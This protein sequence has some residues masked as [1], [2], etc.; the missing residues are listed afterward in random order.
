MPTDHYLLSD[1][2]Y[3]SSALTDST[4][5]TEEA[6]DTDAY[7]N[8]LIFSAAGTGGDWWADDAT[9]TKTPTN[10]LIFTGRRYDP[11]AGI[12]FYRARYYIPD[13]GRF[14]C[15]DP[16][17]YVDGLSLYQFSTS[18][19]PDRADPS[20]T[21]V[22][23]AGA[24]CTLGPGLGA[25]RC[26]FSFRF[27]QKGGRTQ[28]PACR[29]WIV[30]KVV[31]FE[32]EVPCGTMFGPEGG[33]I[34]AVSSN[35]YTYWEAW[36]PFDP[37]EVN[38]WKLGAT[39]WEL[40]H[41]AGVAGR[42]NMALDVAPCDKGEYIAIGYIRFVCESNMGATPPTTWTSDSKNKSGTLKGTNTQPKW[43][44]DAKTF[45]GDDPPAGYRKLTIR[46]CDCGAGDPECPGAKWT[47]APVK[48]GGTYN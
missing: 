18:S 25:F 36:G 40:R 27:N 12:Y 43:W 31:N 14:I 5:T 17:D 45:Q 9:T 2:L 21:L 42:P 22:I 39:D 48:S 16:L 8:T 19:P 1:L 4:G 10:E 28:R 7:G 41:G 34:P 33:A 11:E 32:R 30:Q 37:G 29:G 15:R 24:P 26:S 44:T 6:Y 23:K 3:R 47:K 38:K 13:Q 46:W 20:G 35:I